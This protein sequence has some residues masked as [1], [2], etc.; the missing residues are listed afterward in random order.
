MFASTLFAD[1]N[2]VRDF[3]LQIQNLLRLDRA[4]EAAAIL[5]TALGELDRTGHRLAESC[6]ACPVAGI[7][8]TGWDALAARIAGLDR[9]G[10]PITALGIDISWPGHVGLEPDTDGCLAPHLETNYYSDS[11]FP[12]TTAGRDALLAGYGPYGAEWQG[13][14][15]EI[16][17]LLGTSGLEHLYGAIFPLVES[18]A[19]DPDPE[20]LDADAMRLGAAFVAVRLHQ[21]V[22]RAIRL[23]GLPRPLAV[24]VGSNES[25]PF[26]DAPVVDIGESRTFVRAAPEPVTT[27]A[28]P[29][30]ATTGDDGADELR[31]EEPLA[32]DDEPQIDEP[33]DAV[34]ADDN[35]DD[36]HVVQISGA[37]LRH[38]L[39]Q[40]QA[41]GNPASQPA[42]AAGGLLR[43]LF[44]R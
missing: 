20:P 12:F 34:A 44:A 19:A 6:L 1:D 43:R 33:V 29:T 26:Y 9:F 7:E 24:I 18:V 30:G 32:I 31:L 23:H 3:D 36:D 11:A 40:Q 15:A 25:Y 28:A 41:A 10:A 2:D 27:D 42:A 14:M 5:E 39:V 8:I 22:A 21:A 37:S 4:D 35:G 17:T 38:R 16:D 13:G